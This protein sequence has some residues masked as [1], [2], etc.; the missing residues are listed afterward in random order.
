MGC[1]LVGEGPAGGRVEGG[2]DRDPDVGGDT[3]GGESSSMREELSTVGAGPATTT[4][5]TEPLG[6]TVNHALANPWPLASATLW[7]DLK[8]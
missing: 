3:G 7:S 2:T 4:R 6:W 1:V 8:K 5:A